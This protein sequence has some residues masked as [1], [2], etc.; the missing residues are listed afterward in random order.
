MGI[1]TWGIGG[2]M[3]ADPNNNDKQQTEAL[4]YA[5]NKGVNYVE[6]VYM[7][8]QGK[9]AQ[10]LGNAVKKSK[11]S[12]EKLFI[13]QSIYT[14]TAKTIADA[15]KEVE[16]FLKELDIKF[17]DNLQFTMTSMD[18][19]G[20]TDIANLVNRLLSQRKI[21]YT[22][23]TNSNL[24]YLKKYHQAFGNKMFAHEFCFNFEIREN[25]AEG[26]TKFAAERELLNVVYQPLRRN[27]TAQ[28]NWPLLLELAKKY[29]K[30]QNQI[31]LNWIVSKGFFPLVKASNMKHIDENFASFEFKIEEEDL[32]K[33][34]NF[35]IPGYIS[36]E[37]DW[38]GK[39]RGV[40]IHQLPNVF[41]EIYKL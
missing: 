41:D 34:N 18:Q 27:K 33:L 20:M 5:L 14:S 38:F 15:E 39:G 21:R 2:F 25:E 13:T 7:Y 22:S 32:E 30:T 26:V 9:A 19:Y 6:T 28:R 17:I 8:A 24:D 4:I 16:S 29:D 3:Q 1:G 36:P 40:A 10:L 31:L 23:I 37:I 11:I 35:K 12:R